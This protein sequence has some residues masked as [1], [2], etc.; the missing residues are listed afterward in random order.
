MICEWSDGCPSRATSRV[1]G[2]PCCPACGARARAELAPVVA[3]LRA[4]AATA[5]ARAAAESPAEEVRALEQAEREFGGPRGDR[6]R[7]LPSAPEV[8]VRPPEPPAAPALPR[9]ATVSVCPRRPPPA[10]PAA[11]WQ[12][13]PQNQKRP[14]DLRKDADDH[15][16]LCRVAG[17]ERHRETRGVCKSCWVCLKARPEE[18]RALILLPP[19]RTLFVRKPRIIALRPDAGAHPDL[20]RVD[21]CTRPVRTRG[22]CAGCHW[23]LIRRDATDKAIMLPCKP[24][25]WR[26]P[27]R[28]TL[29]ATV[30]PQSEWVDGRCVVAGCRHRSGLYGFCEDHRKRFKARGEL[31]LGRPLDPRISLASRVLA[32]VVAS[33]GITPQEIAAALGSNLATTKDAIH[34]LRL[35][36]LVAPAT[37][38][39]HSP[40]RGRVYPASAAPIDP[41]VVAIGSTAISRGGVC[42]RVLQL[43]PGGRAQVQQIQEDGTYTPLTRLKWINLSSL[44]I[45]SQSQG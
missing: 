3:P 17:C 12:S 41:P 1:G 25:D 28:L 37:M 7:R 38:A 19:T 33:P 26:G 15:P 27:P 35:R 32:V 18:I 45:K 4:T 22:V 29:R 14:M 40:H 30:T 10:A 9:L 43:S 31:H 11:G 24:K 21:G 39:H 16:G 42:Y 13:R 36:K 5:L 23:L 44:R 2:I 20:C 34:G 8:R 6:A